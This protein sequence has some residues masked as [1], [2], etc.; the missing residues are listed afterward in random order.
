MDVD[1]VWKWCLI[2]AIVPFSSV[3]EL[4]NLLVNPVRHKFALRWHRD[5]VHEEATEAEEMDVLNASH[6]GVRRV[7]SRIV[8]T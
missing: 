1:G 7:L 8:V 6:Y 4:F 5:D 2:E 3:S